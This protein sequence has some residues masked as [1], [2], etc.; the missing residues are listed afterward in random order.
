MRLRLS[1]RGF[2]TLPSVLVAL[3]VVACAAPSRA[4]A[5][6]AH[7]VVSGKAPAHS[8]GNLEIFDHPAAP[9]ASPADD[10]LPPRPKPCSG[11]L[12]SGKPAAPV[13]AP[14]ATGTLRVDQWVDLMAPPPLEPGFGRAL[15]HR[16]RL[17]R[18]VVE[19]ASIERPPRL[20]PML[21]V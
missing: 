13:P 19:G 12:C 21:P 6:C 8:L 1:Q 7:Y 3:A 9:Q 17:V 5:G 10:Q 16:E 14:V 2:R 4:Q 11:A 18:P 15:A 20:S